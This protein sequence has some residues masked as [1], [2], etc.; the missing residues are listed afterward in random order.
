M[1]DKFIYVC[2]SYSIQ[3]LNIVLNLLFIQ[4]LPA[5]TLGDVA[6]AKI[7]LQGFD[8]THLGTR[9]ALDRFLPVTSDRNIRLL[10]LFL[11]LIMVSIL[12]LLLLVVAILVHYPNKIVFSFCL[13]G[14]ILALIGVFKAYFR[15]ISDISK[16]N[17]LVFFAYLTPLFIAVVAAFH[18]FLFFLWIY[19][20]VFFIFFVSFLIK[21]LKE[22]IGIAIYKVILFEVAYRTFTV[23]KLLFL[24]AL[25]IFAFLTVDRFFVDFSLGRVELGNYTVVLFVFSSLFTV[26]SILSELVFPRVVSQ[27]INNRRVF[28]WKEMFFILGAT[29]VALILV[30]IA[31]FF[32][33]DRYTEYGN[34]LPLMQIA[35]IGVL[36]YSFTSIF[37]HVLNA[38]DKRLLI[39]KINLIA[40]AVYV[41]LLSLIFHN[42]SLEMFVLFK[43]LSSVVLLVLYLSVF[44][45]LRK[46]AY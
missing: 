30:N 31:M 26:P 32:L 44:F 1:K 9:F 6:I 28:F 42:A 22:F 38:L 43:V 11:S 34:M 36:P 10:Y 37:Y 21:N 5:S 33:L 2:L 12:S 45:G 29:C 39:L 25:I 17:S 13:V 23:S 14:F 15:A 7:W 35:S 18:G 3:F 20:I 4:K 16:V 41:L 8:Y 27:T 24:N 40:L 46:V 19:P